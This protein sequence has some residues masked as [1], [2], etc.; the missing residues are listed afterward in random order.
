MTTDVCSKKGAALTLA[1]ALLAAGGASAADYPHRKALGER[2]ASV[3]LG[4]PRVEVLERAAGP[5]AAATLDSL[6]ARFSASQRAV[7]TRGDAEREEETH[8]HSLK[9]DGWL[10]Q[11]YAD[12]T[13]VR[14]RNYAALA[15]KQSLA[16][17]VAQ[18]LSEH[19][20]EELGRRFVAIELAG[21]LPLGAGEEL[22]P[23]FTEH[24]I[25]GSG[26]V[27]ATA[28]ADVEDVTAST[29]VFGRT[30]RGVTVIGPG[31][32]VAV[33]FTNDGEAAG[34]DYDWPRYTATGRSQ[35]VIAMPQ[36]RQRSQGLTAVALDGPDVTMRRL[37][38]GYFDAGARRRDA[39]APIQSACGF[40]YTVRTA[41]AP[42]TPNASRAMA[43]Y[44]DVIPAGAFIEPD[45]GWPQ[46][47]RLTGGT[48]EPAPDA[49]PAAPATP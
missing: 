32:K 46:A 9:G 31:S 5:G 11:V 48:P 36:L 14:Y 8:S 4:V 6:R 38:C 26:P 39:S 2:S 17:P 34:F 28:A 29:I 10:L 1:A 47:L 21:L 7:N 20:L 41:V 35:D 43:A 42:G 18:R 24:E 49:P 33:V 16:R 19:E 23:L 12:G 13:R 37:E 30:V 15:G 40:Q 3:G 25:N 44:V 27:S 22:V 45:G